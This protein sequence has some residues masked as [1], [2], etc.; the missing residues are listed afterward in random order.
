MSTPRRVLALLVLA[1]ACNAALAERS[2]LGDE[3]DVVEAGDCEVETAFERRSV[4]GSPRERATSIQLDCGVGWNTELAA[5]FGRTR[6]GG[7]PRDD[8]ASLEMKT[9]LRQRGDGRVGW[10]LVL[11]VGGERQA[12]TSWRRS[13]HSVALEAT[14]EPALGWL[15]EAK[16]GSARDR[17]AR[18]DT[19][20]GLLG[21]EHALMDTLEARAEIDADDRRRPLLRVS[22]RWQFWPDTAALRV[23]YGARSGWERERRVGAA[24]SFEF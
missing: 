11:G 5:S 13:E 24:F 21:V 7:A 6:G 4:P 14:L 19:T 20:H 15:L 22:L 2:R 1:T 3:A 8:A 16:I 18:H 10:A 9:T 17:F 23:S 12:G